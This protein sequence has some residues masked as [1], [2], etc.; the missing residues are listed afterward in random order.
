MLTV[1]T[2]LAVEAHALWKE[3]A[4]ETTQLPGVAAR[5]ETLDGFPL[6]FVEILD[7][8]GENA[9]HKPQG[10]YYTLDITDFW[11]RQP[12]GFQRAAGAVS[13]ILPSLIPEEGPVLICGLG[14]AAMTPDALGPRTL[15]HLL[16]TRH[17]KDVLPGFRPVAAL[18]AGVLGSTGLEAAEWVQGVAE[19]VRPAAVVAV[20]ALAAR[21]LSRLCS[22]V[23]ISDTGLSPGSGVGNHRMALNQETLGVPVIS[24]GVP[25]V[26]DAET[27]ARDILAEAGGTGDAPAAL[28]GQGK[29][30]F[31]TPDSIDAK[32]RELAKLLGYGL[33]MALQPGLDLD[34]LDAL[35]A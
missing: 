13:R 11:K 15:D 9:L 8:E 24:V 30:L 3:S 26:V 7:Q 20:D 32:I 21:E 33:N 35:L 16:I 6:T 31:V 28:H 25:T 22:T 23:Q 34:D 14:N 19:H 1:R 27:V 17:L 12:D 29:R 4:G 18:G 2:D 10:S 5:E